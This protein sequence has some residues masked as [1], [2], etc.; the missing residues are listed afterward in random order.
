MRKLFPLSPHANT[1]QHWQA[2]T[3]YVGTVVY[4]LYRLVFL[5]PAALDHLATTI[6]GDQTALALAYGVCL[7][8]AGLAYLL[9]RRY[10]LDTATT[11]LTGLLVTEGAVLVLAGPWDHVQGWL[12]IGMGIMLAN[13]ITTRWIGILAAAG[14]SAIIAIST[15]NGFDSLSTSAQTERTLLAFALALWTLLLSI[16]P[17][18]VVRGGQL[19]V[20]ANLLRDDTRNLIGISAEV[21]Q[22]ILARTELETF[23]AEVINT[24]QQRFASIYHAQVFLVEEGSQSATLQ[25]STSPVGEKLLAQ[26]HEL[27]IGGL[28]VIGRAT[29]NKKLVLV[30]D[31]TQDT[32]HR[33]PLLLPATRTELGLPLVANDVVIGALDLHSTQINA[34]DDADVAVFEAIANQIAVAIDG[35]Q[36]YEA[37]QRTIRENQALYRQTQTSLREIERLN[38]QLTGRAWTEYLRLQADSTAMTLDL[39][40]GQTVPDTSW[41][42]TLEHAADQHRVITQTVEGQRVVALPIV[43]RNEVIGAMEFELEA[44]GDLPDGALEL[45]TAVSQRLGLALENRRLFDETQ[46]VAQREALINDIGTELQSAIGVDAIIQRAAHNLQEALEAQQVTIRLGFQADDKGQDGNRGTGRSAQEKAPA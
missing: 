43:V 13:L 20:Q 46:R 17:A 9:V 7:G 25:A 24:I 1:F 45:I 41:T 10:L 15:L 37:S 4:V 23:L 42:T 29:L 31:V 32:I 12:V 19:T 21:N 2:I 6:D 35:L 33:P 30:P 36:L 26:E 8:V 44:E 38:Y 27:D 18:L 16:G 28:S 5:F 11:L 34:F 22:A 14:A 39:E 40:S 3:V